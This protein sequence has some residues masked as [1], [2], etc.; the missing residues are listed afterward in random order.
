M[1]RGGRGIAGLASALVLAACVSSVRGQTMSPPDALETYLLERELKEPLAAYLRERLATGSTTERSGVAERLGQLYVEL[2]DEAKTPE[3]RAELER[4]SAE[5]IRIAPDAETFELRINLS[6]ARYLFAEEVAEKHRLRLASVEERR[7]A[8]QTL[9]TL[10]D[11]FAAVGTAAHRR[12][13]SLERLEESG[14]A[15]NSAT[16]RRQLADAR[17]ARSLAM[18][19]AGWSS[20]YL[21]LLTGVQGHAMD[22]LKG[23]GWILNASPGEAATVDRMPKSLL[24][25]EH[26]A[27]AAL[28]CAMAEALRGGDGEAMRWLE[29]VSESED[30]PQTVREQLFARRIVVL[31]TTRRWADLEFYSSR[32]RKEIGEGAPLPLREARLV[33]VYALEA[34]T[35]ADLPERTR[36][37]VESI[38]RQ[39]L[40]DLVSL[41]E[42]GHVVDL[43]SQF[44]SAQLG[45]EGFISNYVRGLH[46]Y[47]GARERH[48]SIG[49]PND[50]PTEDDAM[51]VAYRSVATALEA[52]LDSPDAAAFPRER[53]NAGLLVG[54][55]LF[56]AGELEV[57]A[58]RLEGAYA[59]ATDPKQ[60]EE[61]L[62]MAVVAMDLAAE[63]VGT[64]LDEERDRLA[65]LYLQS[66]PGG[67]RAAKLLLR[68]I[69]HDA[70]DVDRAVEILLA[71]PPDSPIYEASRRQSAQLLYRLFRGSRGRSRDFAAA[72]FLPVAEEVLELDRARIAGENETEAKEAASRVVD[73]V[74]QIL[75]VATGM[76][77][78]DLAR[79]KAAFEILDAARARTNMEIGA[80]EAEIEYRRLQVALVQGQEAEAE[81]IAARLRGIDDEFARLADRQ[82]YARAK[83]AWDA[84]PEDLRAAEQVVEFGRRIIE[85]ARREGF[86]LASDAYA[87]LWSAVAR[88]ANTLYEAEGEERYREAALILDKELI[89][90]GRRA[91]ESIRR[92]A[93]LCESAERIED[94]LNA[95]RMLLAGT[96][97]GSDAW[98]EARYESLRLLAKTDR[99]RAKEAMDQHRLLHPE[100]GPEPWG[101]R[102][103][104]LDGELS[105]GEP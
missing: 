25:L 50:R 81:A 24:G 49:E 99:Q 44:G 71:V 63:R 69:G 98:Y 100:Y 29:A 23:F 36:P 20:Y 80:I 90:A 64:G 10:I 19:Y 62:W 82:M 31:G 74:R 41:G 26:V 32:R 53:A 86:A 87:S 88:A 6:K 103:R 73:R 14:R 1:C 92:Y 54:L 28:G 105:R 13:E 70:I 61:I 89:E 93:R 38:A 56:Y 42:I 65:A 3:R 66:Y 60:A 72:R 22:A 27:R 104:D 15:E 52:A 91:P 39:A 95:W 2:M 9:R 4:L 102:L 76:S 30:L 55:A 11:A 77:T 34:L 37:L 45:D 67:D 85:D 40:A 46:A 68:Q 51:A 43:V 97:A 47:E 96:V 59:A 16:A 35:R 57:A 75:D 101:E 17:R 78:P 8:E 79:A 18:Y 83:R 21:A 48:H 94:A 7:E 5:L 84:R 33:A 12:V 58:R